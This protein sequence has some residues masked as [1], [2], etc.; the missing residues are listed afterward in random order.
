MLIV[1]VDYSCK[2]A[3][4]TVCLILLISDSVGLG[5]PSQPIGYG[6]AERLLAVMGGPEVPA[7][8]RGQVPRITY[9]LGPGMADDHQVCT[10]NNLKIKGQSHEKI[11]FFLL[12]KNLV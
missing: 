3:K 11:L 1:H 9:R 7:D 10:E 6:D 2:R 5:I 12:L 8:W 4:L